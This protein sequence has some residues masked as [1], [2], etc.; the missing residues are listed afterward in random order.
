MGAHKTGVRALFDPDTR[1]Q[2]VAVTHTAAR[3]PAYRD[4][5]GG[6]DPSVRQRLH[7]LGID[8]LYTHQR[9]SYDLLAVDRRH[10]VISTG[11]ASGKTLCFALP[12]L[13]AAAADSMSRSLFVYPTK[14]LAQDQARA[15]ARLAGREHWPAVYDGDTP[16]DQRR[17]IRQRA[18]I[19]LTN[20]DML[21]LGILPAHESWTELFRHLQYVVLDEGHVYRGI[22]GSHVADLVRRL[23]RLCTHYGSDPR[24]VVSSATMADPL[25]FAERLTGLPCSLVDDDGAPHPERTVVLW[26][27]PLEDPTAGR[28]RSA[29]TD[30]VSLVRDAL[31][32]GARAIAF[33]PTRRAAELLYK[34]IQRALAE[35]PDAA[36]RARAARLSPYR[37]GYTPQQRREIERRL[38]DHGLDAVVATSALELGIDVGS[39]DLS[40]VIGFPGTM[41]SLLQRWGRAGRS[42][43]G[44]AVLVAGQDALDQF[45][46]SEPDRLLDRPLERAVIDPANPH[47]LGAHLEAA[48]YELPLTEADGRYF[49]EEGL[50]RAN[51]LT[52]DGRLRRSAAGLVWTLPHAPAAETSL[53]AATGARLTIVESRTG[54]VL[55]ELDLGRAFRT[56]HPGAV[57]LHLGESY[58]VRRLDLD[59]G[60]VL[61]EP[62]HGGYYTQPK[63][64]KNVFVAG[65]TTMREPTAESQLVLGPIEVTEQVVAF[66]RRDISDR[67]VLDTVPL[68]LPEQTF[69]TEAFWLTMAETFTERVSEDSAPQAVA[70]GT[71]EVDADRSGDREGAARRVAGTLHATEHVLIAVLPVRAMC[72]RWDVGGLSTPWHWQTDRATIFV[73][74]AYAGGIG[75]AEAAYDAF[76]DLVDDARRLVSRCPCERGCP[77]CVQSPK[78]GNLNEPLD[79]AG[80][81]RLLDALAGAA[82]RAEPPEQGGPG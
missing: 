53:R 30:A 74:D 59:D 65:Q 17:L 32:A 37:A 21:H 57:Y 66:Q 50:R 69:A 3:A 72:D 34:D 56:A 60:V 81:L 36:V 7:T 26:N 10:T 52:A 80:A 61:V 4:L 70:A 9:T 28:R 33:A 51:A 49:G 44:W 5:P 82:V 42:G 58:I 19:V 23:R 55:G 77:G 45:F 54:S 13:Q 67:R 63:V 75:L 78:C 76:G 22:F 20:P 6:L 18:A 47:V 27:P 71:T 68:D 8:R 46:M 79:K 24:F 73:Y 48:A 31:I 1:E 41:T 35:H 2:I 64:E 43:H 29:L 40:A 12:A 16:G 14:A 11:T 15:L 39:L 25:S 38:F 62:F